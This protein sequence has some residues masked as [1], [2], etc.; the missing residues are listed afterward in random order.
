MILIHVAVLGKLIGCG[1]GA[2]LFGYNF[3]ESGIIGFG[4]NGRGAVE[5]V[6]ATVVLRLSDELM[7][8]KIIV[9]PLLTS[10]QFSALV[11]MAFVTTFLAPI[12]LRWAVIRTCTDTE[13]ADFCRLWDEG[14]N[15][16]Y[17]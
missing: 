1:V 5:L 3:W 16:P 9:D 15:S 17:S 12:S 6:V 10:E 4:M 2:A 7:A 11:I 8:N 14:K 13:R